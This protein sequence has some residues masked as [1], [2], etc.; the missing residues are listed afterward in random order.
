MET[1][2]VL[3]VKT[4]DGSVWEVEKELEKEYLVKSRFRIYISK[5][6]IVAKFYKEKK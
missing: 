2:Q 1:N 6:L 3:C 5:R 4:S